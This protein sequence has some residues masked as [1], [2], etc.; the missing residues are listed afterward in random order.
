VELRT[1]I[2]AFQRTVQIIHGEWYRGNAGGR[3]KK[4]AL[5][6]Y[7]NPAYLLTLS[8]TSSV[9]LIFHQSFGT[10]VPLVNTVQSTSMFFRLQ[11]T[12]NQYL[13]ELDQLHD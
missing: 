3:Q 8:D 11:L 9:Q 7:Q 6:F 2:S 13:Y 1:W 12:K 10:V 5:T 4:T